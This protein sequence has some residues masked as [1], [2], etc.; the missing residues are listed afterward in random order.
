MKTLIIEELMTIGKVKPNSF[1]VVD[2]AAG[3]FTTAI[4]CMNLNRDW[5]CIEKDHEI[6]EIGMNR[7]RE[8][9]NELKK[10]L[11]QQKLM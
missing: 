4:T 7:V 1:L 9:G 5:I 11:M 2:N 8:H 6:F 10:V 3:S